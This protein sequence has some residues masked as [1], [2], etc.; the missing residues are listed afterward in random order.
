MSILYINDN[1]RIASD[2]RQWIIQKSRINKTQ[3]TEW[4]P[5]LYFST[6]GGAVKELKARLIRESDAVGINELVIAAKSVQAEIDSV[7]IPEI[8]EGV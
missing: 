8:L 4:T 7:L 2:S 1:Y 6:L 3:E 5:V